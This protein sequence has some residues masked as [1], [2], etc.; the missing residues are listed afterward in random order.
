MT[1]YTTPLT[2][3]EY[4]DDF[5]LNLKKSKT[6]GSSI[7]FSLYN[8]GMAQKVP[9]LK[10][11]TKTIEYPQPLFEPFTPEQEKLLLQDLDHF[12]NFSDP[13]FY[14]WGDD[15]PTTQL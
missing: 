4:S 6:S 5:A 13:C 14:P 10:I 7:S 12:G 15:E 1:I 9:T 2:W 11:V 3:V 8:T